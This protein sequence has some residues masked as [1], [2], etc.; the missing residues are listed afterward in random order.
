MYPLPGYTANVYTQTG[1][2]P[3]GGACSGRARENDGCVDLIINRCATIEFGTGTKTERLA[4]SW[5][6]RFLTETTINIILIQRLPTVLK[7]GTLA[8]QLQTSNY[9]GVR[10]IYSHA[11]TIRGSRSWQSALSLYGGASAL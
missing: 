3:T 11:D 7:N 1:I 5:P 2:F 8:I 9:N 10:L 4:R 6:L